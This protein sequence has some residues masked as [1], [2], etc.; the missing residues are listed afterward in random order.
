MLKKV[1]TNKA[2]FLNHIRETFSEGLELIKNKNADYADNEDPFKNFWMS[3]MVGVSPERAIL[4]RI[5]DKLARVS[6]LLDKEADV[7]DETIDDTILD[8]VNYFAIL[9]ALIEKKRG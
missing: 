5:S 7:E 1:V 4:V 2:W 8:C 6:N 9:R 3:E